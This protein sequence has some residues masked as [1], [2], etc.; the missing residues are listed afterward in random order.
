MGVLSGQSDKWLQRERDTQS[1]R[2]NKAVQVKSPLSWDDNLA[3]EREQLSNLLRSPKEK[4]NRMKTFL[5]SR[6]C[7][8]RDVARGRP[9]SG[10]LPVIS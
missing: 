2:C 9:L 5:T 7:F 3:L 10:R 4:S 6:F 1:L 8:G